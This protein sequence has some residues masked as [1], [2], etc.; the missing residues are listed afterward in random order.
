[1]NEFTPYSRQDWRDW[2]EQN[3]ISQ[4][5]IYLIYHKKSSG[6]PSISWQEAVEEALCFGW[7][8]STKKKIDNFHYQQLF[9]R[10][11]DKSTWSKINKELITKLAQQ[12]LMTEHGYERVHL[13]KQNGSWT[14]L[15]DCYNHIIPPDLKTMLTIHHL[16]EKF[17]SLTNSQK[18]AI[19]MQLH[20]KKR[21]ET[22]QKVIISLIRNKLS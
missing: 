2:L 12:G 6:I 4:T 21:P 18:T 13:A 19:L 17:N 8:D 15:D 5:S 22:R 20:D 1:M 3:S 11:K 16:Q 9:T 10:R 7:I 14:I